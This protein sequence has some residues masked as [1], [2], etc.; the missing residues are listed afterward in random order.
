MKAQIVYVHDCFHALRQLNVDAG[1]VNEEAGID[2]VC[3]SLNLAAAQCRQ[4]TVRLDQVH[5]G[6]RQTNSVAHPERKLPTGEVWIVEDRIETSGSSI[7]RI[8]VSLSP[9]KRALE[10][11][12]IPVNR[13][14]DRSH[15]R[16]HIHPLSSD[17]IMLVVSKREVVRV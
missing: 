4:E 17:R 10:S 7:R 6:L 2:E 1:V 12:V 11:Q 8:P 16:S 5:A 13:R 14:L 15:V 3:L 9:Q